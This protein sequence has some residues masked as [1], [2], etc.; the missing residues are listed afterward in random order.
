M[1]IRN[2]DRNH[3]HDSMT[4]PT[5]EVVCS[6]GSFRWKNMNGVRLNRLSHN[7]DLRGASLR[8]ADARGFDFTAVSIQRNPVEG[9]RYDETTT[10]PSP[11]EMLAQFH[12]GEL[13]PGLTRDLMLYD[14]ANH[15]NPKRFEL[16]V[17]RCPACDAKDFDL[18]F[19]IDTSARHIAGCSRF[20][21]CPYE[22]DGDVRGMAQFGRS[23]KFQESH[24]VYRRITDAQKE[25]PPPTAL[26]L[27]I[28]LLAETCKGPYSKKRK[29]T[30][31]TTARKKTKKGRRR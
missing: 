10:F 31:K 17:A 15:P 7:V 9:L 4:L 2:C 18:G 25:A 24:E 27:V 22:Q 19:E 13:S 6:G 26:S 20:G 23:A 21:M 28:R 8:G 5:G 29:K 1:T 16:W 12:W 30:T 11:P 3:I 14:R